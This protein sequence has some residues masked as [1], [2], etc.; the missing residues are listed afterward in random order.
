MANTMQAVYQPVSY[1]LGREPR[2]ISLI[3]QN[4]TMVSNAFVT[5]Q[6]RHVEFFTAPPQDYTLLGNN[7]WLNLLAVHEFRHVVQYDKTL[8][9]LSKVMY[10][11]FGNNGLAISSIT[12][13]NWFWEGD[14][15]GTE[16]ALTP[17]GRGRIPAF[18]RAFRT[19]L[20]TR[21][22]FSYQKAYL[23]SYKDYVPNHYVLGYFMT[24]YLKRNYGKDGWNHI[25]TRHNNFPFQPFR[26]SW[27]IKK[28]TKRDV[29]ELYDDTMK[30]LDSFWQ[31]QIKDLPVSDA[32]PLPTAK[33]RVYT[34]YEFPQY[35]NDGHIVAQKSGMA[36]IEQFVV[37]GQ[38][39]TE[40]KVFVPGFVNESGMLSVINNRIVWSEFAYD[41]RWGLRDYSVLKIYD[42]DSGKQR[43]ITQKTRLGAPALSPD[44][45]KIVA[46]QVSQTNEF[47]LV[48][49]DSQTGV[50]TQTLPNPQNDFYQMPR[51]S[52]DGKQIVVIQQRSRGEQPGKTIQL[53]DVGSGE[54]KQ[55]L[56]FSSYNIAHPVL[57]GEYVYYNSPFNG[58]D[59]IYALHLPSG[60]QYQVT[61]RKFGAYNPAIS[62]DGGEIAFNDF[63]AD[64]FRVVTM[65]NDPALWT[66][67]EKVQDR[68]VAYYKP[69]LEQEA[70]EQV[71]TTV[72][73][74]Q[75]PVSRYRK[76]THFFNPYSWGPVLTSTGSS[77]NVGI[78]SQD[79]LNT[80]QIAA[81]Y[82]FNSNE[83]AGNFFAQLS[84]QG[85]YPI[86]DVEFLSGV[87]DVIA[88]TTANGTTRI[89]EDSWRENTVTAGMRLPLTLTHSKYQEG[90]TLSAYTS[91]IQTTGYDIPRIYVTEVGNNSLQDVRYRV[92]YNRLLKMSQRDVA[93][94][95]GQAFST[96]FRH[97]PFNKGLQGW[98]YIVQGNLYFPGLLKH[99][100]LHLR[101]GY[102][103]ED[104]SR[105]Q[106]SYRFGSI[107]FYP[108]GHN[109]QSFGW[110]T[111][112]TIEYGFPI[113]NTDWELGRFFYFQRFKGNLFY[114]TAMGTINNKSTMIQ[115]IGF[116]LS[117]QF[118]FM[119]LLPQLEVG[120]RT[121]YRPDKKQPFIFEPVVLNVGF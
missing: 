96:Q 53:I 92:S 90:L 73:D 106:N 40:R 29:E 108:R 46:V 118:N 11:L 98:Q 35:L 87:R 97:T 43:K 25:L 62:P 74:T 44:G 91:Y 60:K 37:L 6:P 71:L 28:E 3:L 84:Y 39:A 81:G 86:I 31:W 88:T 63:T 42:F 9:G 33:N 120:V 76:G 95:W 21:G 13:P 104:V 58:I 41:P 20:L 89:L 48:I 17:G 115:S 111:T 109:Y 75:Y 85:F 105:G 50:V 114:D 110:L 119:R 47:A 10:Y 80:T 117:T 65:P 54:G 83:D 49:I 26:F 64:G 55:L 78:S 34:N 121:I 100:S 27:A 12:S 30:E 1:T 2:P 15:V 102:Q 7:D 59:N 51:W 14:A 79:L 99:H 103:R 72:G 69:L 5:V 77:L 4:Q 101:G 112:S 19:N 52:P 61:S 67:L 94:R 16:T 68:T 82:G 113:I 66:S 32:V 93:P 18:D 107:I 24:T 45:S 22:P 70:N 38:E 23:R 57:A 56:P 116:D 36:D 8:T